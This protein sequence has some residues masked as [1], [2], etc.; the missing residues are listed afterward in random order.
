MIITS[1]PANNNQPKSETPSTAQTNPIKVE[2]IQTIKNEII[3]T[4]YD[5][6]NKNQQETCYKIYREKEED[7]VSKQDL[8]LI[9]EY[10]MM[11]RRELDSEPLKPLVEKLV[12]IPVY[13]SPIIIEKYGKAS[14]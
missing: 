12:D 5:P 10:F 2:N 11:G 7:L 14:K 4:F 8:N 3:P 6:S 13:F 1:S 9:K